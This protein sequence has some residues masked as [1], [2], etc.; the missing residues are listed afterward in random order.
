M[1]K[2]SLAEVQHP[3]ELILIVCHL[4]RHKI[5]AGSRVAYKGHPTNAHQCYALAAFSKTYLKESGHMPFLDHKSMRKLS[6]F[7]HR[8]FEIFA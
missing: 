6:L 4:H 3:H 8:I 1:T 2:H 5:Q 7:S